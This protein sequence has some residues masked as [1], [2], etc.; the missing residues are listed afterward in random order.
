[1]YYALCTMHYVLFDTHYILC[2]VHCALYTIHYTLFDIHY[3]LCIVYCALCT[4]H[5]ALCQDALSP[6]RPS[7]LPTIHLMFCPFF[8]F[9]LGPTCPFFFLFLV[10]FN[11]KTIYFVLVSIS[12]ILIKYSLSICH[13]S[14]FFKNSVFRFHST[15][16]A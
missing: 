14:E 12:F 16:V 7:V 3:V 9:E 8:F 6:S 2:I 10:R 15:F 13:F 1:M 4:M 11:P 5:Y